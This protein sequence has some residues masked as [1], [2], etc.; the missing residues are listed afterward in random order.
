VE[1]NCE[2]Q[3]EKQPSYYGNNIQE[4]YNQSSFYHL[5]KREGDKRVI[6][7]KGTKING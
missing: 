3:A 2:T 5:C 1:Q 6:K 7:I 4:K